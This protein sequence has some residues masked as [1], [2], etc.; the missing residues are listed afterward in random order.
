MHSKVFCSSTEKKCSDDSQRVSTQP[1]FCF[2]ITM[3][4]DTLS[5]LQV[6]LLSLCRK[7]LLHG[8]HGKHSQADVSSFQM[9]DIYVLLDAGAE[10]I[11]KFWLNKRLVPVYNQ[12]LWLVS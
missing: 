6:Y 11:G 8:D 1:K 3:V 2:L 5:A 10:H 7:Y 12:K 9:T 4:D